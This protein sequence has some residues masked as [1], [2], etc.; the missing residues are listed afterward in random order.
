MQLS[1]APTT[2]LNYRNQQFELNGLILTEEDMCLF[3]RTLGFI[4]PDTKGMD[5]FFGVLASIS[6]LT[7]DELTRSLAEFSSFSDEDKELFRKHLSN[8]TPVLAN[9]STN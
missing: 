9:L 8:L 6:Q 4:V 2:T 7:D 1:L 5:L 3:L